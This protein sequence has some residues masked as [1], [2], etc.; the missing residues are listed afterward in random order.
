MKKIM[1]ALAACSAIGLLNSC[2]NKG[3]NIVLPTHAEPQVPERPFYASASYDQTAKIITVSW[4]NQGDATSYRIESKGSNGEWQYSTTV[5]GLSD[6][7]TYTGVEPGEVARFLSFRVIAENPAGVSS[8][9]ETNTVYIPK[10]EA[11]AAGG[12]DK[13][14]NKPTVNLI[15]SPKNL[16]AAGE[17]TFSADAKDDKE[18]AKVEFYD[19]G[20]LLGTDDSAPYEWTVKYSSNDNGSHDIKAVASD[21]SGNKGEDT[22][23]L[24]VDIK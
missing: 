5:S 19:N 12:G 15:I 1:L 2:D 10:K 17:V 6:Q 23:T 4:R 13:D 11:N 7:I 9:Q 21:K 16:T 8:P 14:T 18:V 22:G 20:K 3:A 24:T